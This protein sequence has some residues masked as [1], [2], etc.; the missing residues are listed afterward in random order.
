MWAP[1]LAVLT[2]GQIGQNV[3]KELKKFPLKWVLLA[4]AMAALP[5]ILSQFIYWQFNLANWNNAFALS[6]DGSNTLTIVNKN[7]PLGGSKQNYWYF[8]LNFSLLILILSAVTT[9]VGA[10]GEEIGWRGFLQKHIEKHFSFFKATV[11]VAFIWAYWH[12][13][14]NLGGTN[15]KEHTELVTFIIFPIGVFF[16]TFVLAWLRLKSDAIWPC[17]V[18]HGVGNTC[19]NIYL[20][21]PKTEFTA[22]LV[23]LVSYF[24]VWSVFIYLVFKRSRGTA[25]KL[26]S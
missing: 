2:L 20:F 4:V 1:T 24:L 23:N 18:F 5:Y 19:A 13:P 8:A 11:V 22:N 26:T 14:A 7:F 10:V 6:N 12:I 16:T 15:G 21:E 17:A 3:L 9:L 25:N